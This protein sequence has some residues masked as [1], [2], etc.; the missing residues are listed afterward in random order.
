[1]PILLE[2]K[3]QFK[4][5]ARK[6]L[7]YYKFFDFNMNVTP[8]CICISLSKHEHTFFWLMIWILPS[9]SV[10]LVF[11]FETAIKIW[12]RFWH[13]HFF[14]EFFFP[15]IFSQ[16]FSY[17]LQ[18]TSAFVLRPLNI[19]KIGKCIRLRNKFKWMF[20]E[21]CKCELFGVDHRFIQVNDGNNKKR[22]RFPFGK[23]TINTFIKKTRKSSDGKRKNGNFYRRRI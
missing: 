9:K 4:T 3:F 2:I 17:W 13:L 14:S 10:V 23:Q 8:I 12:I 20:N 18:K 16:H 5:C 15:E 7:K 21:K 19:T 11:P 6:Y 1:M 22:V